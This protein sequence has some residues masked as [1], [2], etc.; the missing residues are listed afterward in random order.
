[1]GVCGQGL[2]WEDSSITLGLLVSYVQIPLP[3][4]A[5]TAGRRVGG[6]E[7]TEVFWHRG[8]RRSWAQ[9]SKKAHRSVLLELGCANSS[10]SF[11][12]TRQGRYKAS[13][14]TK[15][16]KAVSARDCELRSR[17]QYLK[18]FPDPRDAATLGCGN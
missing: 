1:M 5:G 12:D 15:T 6:E 13:T 2:C 16:L 11:W 4:Q 9:K 17:G 7:T 14:F 10:D 8:S 3:Q 18:V